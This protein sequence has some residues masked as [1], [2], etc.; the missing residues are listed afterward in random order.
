MS[1]RKTLCTIVLSLCTV[2]SSGC[3]AIPSAS[4]PRAKV[5]QKA[6]NEQKPD[7]I[8]V[9]VLEYIANSEYAEAQ[10]LLEERNKFLGEQHKRIQ[11]IQ[12]VPAY[13]IM[14]LPTYLTASQQMLLAISFS[15]TRNYNSA[16]REFRSLLSRFKEDP[17][18]VMDDVKDNLEGY[19]KTKKY[20]DA[21]KT[22]AGSII[23]Y[24]EL[25]AVV[26]FLKF[27]REDYKG[28]GKYFEKAV[29]MYEYNIIFGYRLAFAKLLAHVCMKNDDKTILG[30]AKVLGKVYNASAKPYNGVFQIKPE[31][32]KLYELA[33]DVADACKKE[34][35]ELLKEA[36]KFALTYNSSELTRTMLEK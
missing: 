27:A 7:K 16:E 4:V 10:G 22:A 13:N 25:T 20:E 12:G 2:F 21:E 1:E 32:K 14:T 30:H 23:F 17:V 33:M 8:V 36:K 9:D 18:K 11:E 31:D 19:L 3:G 15:K 6:D 28:A 35:E 26:G 24:P 5:E 29:P 34:D